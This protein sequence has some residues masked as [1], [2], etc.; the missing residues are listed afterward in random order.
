MEMVFGL[1]FG[2]GLW[3]GGGYGGFVWE[4]LAQACEGDAVAD[5]KS[6]HVKRA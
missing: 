4:T 5:E 2:F 6:A 1:D 3:G